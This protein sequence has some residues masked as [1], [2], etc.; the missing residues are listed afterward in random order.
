M[1]S[2]QFKING[3]DAAASAMTEHEDRTR[4]LSRIEEQPA[5]TLWSVHGCDRRGHDQISVS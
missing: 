5:G 3:A 1:L 2:Q 4:P